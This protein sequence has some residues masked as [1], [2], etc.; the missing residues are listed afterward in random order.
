MNK[1]LFR[2]G[3]SLMA[4][5]A[6]TASL[7]VGAMAAEEDGLC[8]H[9][10]GHTDD[11]GYEAT[12]ECTHVCTTDSG[13]ITVVCTHTHVATCFD[14]EGNSMCRH[15]CTENPDCYTPTV[16][17]LHLEHGSCGHSEGQDCEFA[18]NGCEQCKAAAEPE[19]PTEP[20]VPTQPETPTEP[21]VPTQPE[22]PTEPEVPTQPEEEAKPDYKITKG[23]GGKWNQKSGKDLSF[24]L[25]A[26]AADITAIRIDGKLLE[27]TNYLLKTDGVVTLKNSW[28]E[29]QAIGTYRITFE[30]ADGQVSGSFKVAAQL[31]ETNP[32]T[33]DAIN[34]WIG[35][36]TASLLAAAVLGVVGYRYSRKK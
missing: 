17:C 33:G 15:A 8:P 19:T 30:F 11:C 5:L 7:A 31:D 16:N 24:T 32:E 10:P 14:A 23:N 2:R 21:E 9:H 20:E 18:V 27:G 35:M 34:L 36:L 26:Y 25:N 6:L 28:L 1:T 4:C 12:G 3:I 29:K 13:C 22:T